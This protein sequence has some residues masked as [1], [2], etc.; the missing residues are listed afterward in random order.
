[1]A[2]R[3]FAFGLA[4]VSESGCGKPNR[5][6]DRKRIR[7][8]CMR[9]RNRTI[10]VPRRPVHQASPAPAPRIDSSDEGTSGQKDEDT[11][12]SMSP[13]A[14][15]LLDLAFDIDNDSKAHIF[16][17]LRFFHETM[18]PIQHFIDFDLSDCD[19]TFWLFLDP[20]Y[21]QSMFFLASGTQDLASNQPLTATTYA[22]LRQTIVR[23]NKQLSNMDTSAALRDSTVAVV[24]VLTLFS[25]LIN[26]QPGAEAHF[27]GLR[28]MVR[29]R[30]GIQSFR[31]NTKLYLKLA[32]ADLIHALSTGST[33][34]L[35]TTP[36]P[37]PHFL[38]LEP[39][40][41]HRT[42]S[43]D[44][45]DTSAIHNTADLRILTT[46]LE[47]QHYTSLINAVHTTHQRRPETEFQTTVI[48]F[49][50]RLLQLQ[51][52]FHDKDVLSE[53]LCLG[54]LAFLITTYQFPGTR[55]AYPVLGTRLREACCAL[56]IGTEHKS[57]INELMR[58]LLIVGAMSV[59][60][61]ASNTEGWMVE[62]WN[63]LDDVEWEEAKTELERV[64]W[65]GL[66]Q[67]RMGRG[68]FEELNR[69]Q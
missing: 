32:R 41:V 5:S 53:C 58:W 18:Y 56:H 50:Y 44:F 30:G 9:G 31:N 11:G 46:F 12:L 67:D 14:L 2:A 28:Q 23:L 49:Q 63:A 57:E 19:W 43:R 1:M 29:L 42:H 54:M 21:L 55:A 52:A 38:S 36:I 10:G 8:H 51:N 47:M 45:D 6:T 59:F 62:R 16:S 68:V 26:D 60:D 37:R 69:Q 33:G 65:I 66:L 39:L 61:L 64:I 24:I 3:Q 4:F 27:A 7:S 13:S 35:C 17:F 34:L 22:F 48:S 25:S 15:S 40:T 20:A